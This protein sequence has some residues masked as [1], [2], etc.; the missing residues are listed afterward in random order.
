MKVTRLE[1]IRRWRRHLHKNPELSRE[2]Y[3]TAAYIRAELEEMGLTYET[4][5]D[6]GTI[7]YIE[8]QGK[9][10]ILLAA[11]IDGLP[12]REMNEGEFNSQNE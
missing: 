12:I 7:V 10:T 9:D 6:T 3:K 1:D 11:D 2:E 4:C 8:G 5:L